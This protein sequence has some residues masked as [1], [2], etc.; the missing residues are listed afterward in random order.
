M[1]IN[2]LDLKELKRSSSA[3]N[4]ENDILTEYLIGK[5]FDIHMQS[6]Q[7]LWDRKMFDEELNREGSGFL[8]C[9]SDSGSADGGDNRLTLKKFTEK[10]IDPAL[11][12]GL[13]SVIVGFFI[14]Y[15][16]LDEMHILD[17]TV[18]KE[19]QSKG[20]G[21]LML[22]TVIK[23]KSEAGIK[24]FFLEVRTS[25]IA[26]INLYKKL[27]FKIFMLRKK[28]YEDN[29]EDALCMVKES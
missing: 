29:G 2:F 8:I 11:K 5:M 13:Q 24:H 3:N 27:G 10:D 14:Y 4:D 15:N 21:S 16:V 6:S 9:Y 12:I 7:T 17:I 20:I 1:K 18:S 22:S 25:N 26:A 28:Y 19:M 23:K